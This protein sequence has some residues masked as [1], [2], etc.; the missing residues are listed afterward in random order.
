M[1]TLYETEVIDLL[2]TYKDETGEMMTIQV[3]YIEIRKS[4][5]KVKRRI[6]KWSLYAVIGKRFGC[7]TVIKDNLTLFQAI[8]F[9]YAIHR[10]YI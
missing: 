6:F 3:N 7:T 4:G 9:K 10:R 2:A 8:K 5:K 1:V